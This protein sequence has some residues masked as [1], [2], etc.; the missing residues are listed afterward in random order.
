[1]FGDFETMPRCMMSLDSRDPSESGE[2]SFGKNRRARGLKTFPVLRS[3]GNL[4]NH[5]KGKI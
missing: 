1:M 3:K 5:A 2:S 4:D